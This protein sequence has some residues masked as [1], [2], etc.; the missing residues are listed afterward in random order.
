ME[1]DTPETIESF[2]RRQ[3]LACAEETYR[4]FNAGLI[5][6][7]D[8][9]HMLGVRMP[10]LRRIARSLSKRDD[11]EAFLGALP[12]ATYEEDQLHAIVV[13]G[14]RDYDELIG[15]LE[16]FLPY[17]DNWAT[18][19]AL[20]PKALSTRPEETLRQVHMW[21]ASG[22]TY[23][24]RCGIG[25]LRTLYLGDR[26]EPSQLEGVASLAAGDYYIDMARAWYVAEA[27]VRQEQAALALLR[28]GSLDAWTHNKAIQKALE[29][30]KIPVG[31]KGQLRVLRRA[32]AVRK[33]TIR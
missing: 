28:A 9:N 25:V 17:V 6:T 29:S 8:S 2:I 18:C 7:V 20:S 24:V 3:L 13:S 30:R 10:E 5:P 16:R 4:N 12:H 33:P 32:D 23:V 26:F 27:L 21:L 11:L 15:E 1:R 19:D 22:E 14:M 31:L